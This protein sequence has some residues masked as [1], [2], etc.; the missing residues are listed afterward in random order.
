MKM[1]HHV[2]TSVEQRRGCGIERLAER[3]WNKGAIYYDL[4]TVQRKIHSPKEKDTVDT[5][6]FN[7]DERQDEEE[8]TAEKKGRSRAQ[9][10]W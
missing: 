4:S 1:A 10:S 3:S 9:R 8:Y 7:E 5:N 2:L 6:D